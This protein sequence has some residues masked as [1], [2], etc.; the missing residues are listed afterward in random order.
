MLAPYTSQQNNFDKRKNRTL[1]V[2]NFMILNVKLLFNLLG[3]TLL[4][5]CHVHNKVSSLKMQVLP[6]EL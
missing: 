6:Y 2:V 5:A 3:E 4:T 1:T